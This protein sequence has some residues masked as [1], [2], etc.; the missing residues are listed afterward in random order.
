[1]AVLWDIAPCSLVIFTDVSEELNASLITLM[2][3]TVSSQKIAKIIYKLFCK[4]IL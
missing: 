2:I 1:M 3:E 4:N